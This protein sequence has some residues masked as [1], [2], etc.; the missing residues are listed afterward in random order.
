MSCNC[1]SSCNNG[2]YIS[3][4]IVILG[5]EGEKCRELMEN[6]RKALKD[7]GI[8]KPLTIITDSESIKEYGVSPLPALMINGVIICAGEV[9]SKD[10]ILRHL[11]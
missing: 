2:D 6:T 9:M 5:D 8:S 10:D 3:K 11:F 7:L 1:N 4:G